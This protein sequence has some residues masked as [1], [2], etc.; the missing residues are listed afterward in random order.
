MSNI[1]TFSTKELKMRKKVCRN[2]CTFSKITKL[3]KEIITIELTYGMKQ[4]KKKTTRNFFYMRANNQTSITDFHPKFSI[5][6]D[7]CP[8]I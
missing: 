4:C 8:D 7:M 3:N 5:S 2:L 1:R 6:N